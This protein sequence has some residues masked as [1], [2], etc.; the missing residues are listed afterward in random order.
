MLLPPRPR[1]RTAWDIRIALND[2]VTASWATAHET[3]ASAVAT[4]GEIC[5]GGG[6]SA[7]GEGGAATTA[8]PSPFGSPFAA[9]QPGVAPT[10]PPLRI[11]FTNLR[12]VAGGTSDFLSL[13]A[14]S[15]S[16][17][18]A[19]WTVEA[20]K[21]AL[22]AP[23][24]ALA[25]S[26]AAALRAARI[27]GNVWAA[28]R[29]G[30]R[31]GSLAPPAPRRGAVHVRLAGVRACVWAD[32]PHEHDGAAGG[33]RCE[34]TLS[35]AALRCSS[36][37]ARAGW[38]ASLSDGALRY[39]ERHGDAAEPSPPLEV[40]VLLAASL[41]L[42]SEPAEGAHALRLGGDDV[43]ARWEPDAHFLAQRIVS[44]A[45][46]SRAAAAA[47]AVTGAVDAFGRPLPLAVPSPPGTAQGAAAISEHA[48]RRSL[49]VDLGNLRGELCAS[50][51]LASSFT[52]ARVVAET[53]RGAAT[54]GADVA[55]LTIGVNGQTVL[56]AVALVLRPPPPEEGA[57][58][59]AAPSPR[60]AVTPLAATPEAGFAGGAAGGGNGAAALTAST[61]PRLARSGT[62]RGSVRR[63]ASL[64]RGVDAAVARAGAILAD[65]PACVRR[66]ST[67]RAD[68]TDASLKLPHKLDLGAALAAF[69]TF[70][71]AFRAA[72]GAPFLARRDAAAT[73]A[74]MAA[75]P[76]LAHASGSS[77]GREPPL[78][79]VYVRMRGGVS[80][81]AE[82]APM[83]R[84]L[85]ARR[86]AAAA[87]LAAETAR[88]ASADAPGKPSARTAA[89]CDAFPRVAAAVAVPMFCLSGEEADF[90]LVF[91]G[92]AAA[93][94]AAAEIAASLDPH[95]C[96]GVP[97]T[98]ARAAC[99]DLSVSQLR[100]RVRDHTAPLLVA[101]TLCLSGPIVMARQAAPAPAALAAAVAQRV[102]RRRAAHLAAPPAPDA[103]LAPLKLWTD[104]RLSASAF[105]VRR[106]LWRGLSSVVIECF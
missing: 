98:V 6:D 93:L 32:M 79:E 104:L 8:G 77:G 54:R 80:V 101:D 38:H 36:H 26:V 82:E 81:L 37:P 47:A 96:Q 88:P 99:V 105:T 75:A 59:G 9:A 85:H 68:V 62:L 41:T 16:R 70:T 87:G 69:E 19:D 12:A 44:D 102:G 74:S 5:F 40:P 2:G 39:R 56:S 63:S 65:T 57:P 20:S 83:E 15:I 95:G 35:L 11:A 25:P 52:C 72:G 13:G 43:S 71:K 3:T 94:T 55:A 78:V 31:G 42:A 22:A 60:V 89:F 92:G 106:R 103:P 28:W 7:T 86:R 23:S 67:W 33:A 91:G 61:L 21:C 90:L 1:R 30:A 66:R 24:A 51:C 76:L 58:D 49:S 73:A 48:P 17:A 100:L 34:A 27:H 53:A 97:L 14:L 10:A 4:G 84:W 18:R 45:V 46:A 50:S 29:R 64:D